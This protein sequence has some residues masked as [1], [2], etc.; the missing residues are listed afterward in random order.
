MKRLLPFVFSLVAS[1]AA[2]QTELRIEA[3]SLVLT[4]IP[5]ELTVTAI[6]A[7]GNPVPDYNGSPAI[8]GLASGSF[9]GL[10]IEEAVV[11]PGGSHTLTVRDGALT[12]EIEI[13]SIPGVL[14]ILPP[15]LAI[16]L[17]LVFRQVVLSLFAG[18]WL[19][20]TFIND[21]NILAG[22]LRGADALRHQRDHD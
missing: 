6:D 15:I 10:T 16:T 21:Y 13:R 7:D 5:F 9:D 3:P 22:F 2:A 4:G 1:I 12:G 20:A 18:I 17:A 8:T 11:T 14:S 19:A